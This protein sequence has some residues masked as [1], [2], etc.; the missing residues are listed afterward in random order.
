MPGLLVG[1]GQSGTVVRNF[2]NLPHVPASCSWSAWPWKT[3]RPNTSPPWANLTW[4]TAGATI[5]EKGADPICAIQVIDL[6]SGDVVQTLQISGIVEELYDVV[7]ISG[8]RRPMALGFKSDKL[9]RLISVGKSDP[10]EP[11]PSTTPDKSNPTM[12]D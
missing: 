5:A 2:R 9:R 1:S 7:A 3:A 12:V 10:P 11:E 8:I 6:R 4:R